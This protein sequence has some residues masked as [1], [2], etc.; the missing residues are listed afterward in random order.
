MAYNKV[1]VMATYRRPEYTK[2]ALE[3]LKNCYGIED[4]KIYIQAEPGF[5][6]VIDAIMSVQGVN[7]EISVHPQRLGCNRNIFKALD[8]GFKLS[9]Y[10]IIIE[11]DIVPAKDC[12]KFFEWGS[13][14]YK[15]DKQIMNICSY[16]RGDARPDEYYNVGRSPWFTPWGWATW[17]DRWQEMVPLWDHEGKRQSWDTTVNHIIRKD[18]ME[19]KPKLARTQNIGAENGSWVPSAKWH[20]ENHFNGHWSGSVDDE[21]RLVKYEEK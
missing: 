5:P 12:L 3:G 9:D 1:I 15:D 19:I 7:K 8:F 18:R 14:K 2:R 4:Y 11:D 16:Q 6:D 13:E 10:V 21:L 17:Q 20:A